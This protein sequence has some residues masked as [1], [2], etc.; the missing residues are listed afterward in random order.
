MI[1]HNGITYPSQAALARAYGITPQAVSIARKKDRMDT[2]GAGRGVFG[3]SFAN[4]ARRQPVAACGLSWPSQKACAD[5]L[6]SYTSQVA[7]AL[8]RGTFESWVAKR[9]RKLGRA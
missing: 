1:T 2:I 5:D 3:W 8:K 7:D 9:L 4:T 6:G